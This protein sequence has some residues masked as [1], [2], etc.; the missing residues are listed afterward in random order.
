MIS[1][2][3]DSKKTSLNI[4]DGMAFNGMKGNNQ[5]SG[6]SHFKESLEGKVNANFQ[7]DSGKQNSM[8]G[9]NFLSVGF[10]SSIGTKLGSNNAKKDQEIPYTPKGFK[11]GFEPRT[12]THAHELS[13]NHVEDMETDHNLQNQSQSQTQAFLTNTGNG[14]KNTLTNSSDPKPFDTIGPTIKESNNTIED[15]F[16]DYGKD[17]Q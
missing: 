2:E 14:D 1:E 13:P 5:N 11:N 4:E 17:K 12:L 8:G 15:E 10:D 3:I 6:L 16:K 7:L 9:S